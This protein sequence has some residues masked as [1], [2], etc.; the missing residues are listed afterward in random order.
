VTNHASGT[1]DVKVTPQAADA[2]D[3][4][5]IS[6][7]SLDKHFR[8]D[9]EASSKGQMLATAIVKAS[10]G[11][12]AIERVTGTLN[13]R[14]GTFALQHVGAMTQGV[15]ELHIAVVP[16]SGTG[17]LTGLAGTM[18]IRIDS[19]KHSYDFEYT[20]PPLP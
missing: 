8:D 11:Y 18:T 5:G 20:L 4:S 1:F 2:G 6:R 13:G 19:G 16:D 12:V 7:M 17:Q 9:L 3:D 15:P 14:N 10:G